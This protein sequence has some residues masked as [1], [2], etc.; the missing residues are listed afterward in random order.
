MII[1]RLTQESQ[2]VS[3]SFI[4]VSGVILTGAILQAKGRI[5][6]TTDPPG[7]APICVS[8]VWLKEVP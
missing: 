6:Q 2:S 3:E 8:V 5:S 4:T 1:S 7:L